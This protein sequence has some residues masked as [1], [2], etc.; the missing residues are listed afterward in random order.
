MHDFDVLAIG[1]AHLDILCETALADLGVRDAPGTVRFAAGGTAY[2]IAKNLS[3]RGYRTALYTHLNPIGLSGA[4]VLSDLRQTTIS[5][6]FVVIDEAMPESA[7]CARMAAGRFHD[8]VSAMAIEQARLDGA[9]L[10]EAIAAAARVVV[11]CNL[12]QAQI[13]EVLALS[14]RLGRPVAVAC[15]SAAKAGRYLGAVGTEAKGAGQPALAAMNRFEFESLTGHPLDGLS[16]P[17]GPILVRLRSRAG[18]ISDGDR[19]YWG[20]TETGVR[21]YPAQPAARPGPGGS[22][23]GAGDAL[24]AAHCAVMD[25]AG[26]VDWD[27]AHELF[28]AMIPRILD[29]SGATVQMDGA[30]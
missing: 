12:L 23:L 24:I 18:L 11:D 2:N 9:I 27:A 7:F 25:E 10:G 30:F 14:A 4:R 17:T 13:A 1:S 15:V 6:R 5:E 3:Q 29:E 19:G 21:P 20:V 22:D 28:S 26:D 16:E 8:A